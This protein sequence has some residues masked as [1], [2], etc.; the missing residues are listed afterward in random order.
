MS[1]NITGATD[2]AWQA[3]LT[4]FDGNVIGVGAMLGNIA[5]ESGGFEWAC[6][7]SIA[8]TVCRIYIS[9]VDNGDISRYEFITYG[10]NASTGACSY[11]TNHKGFGLCQW[12]Y[13]TRKAM[14]WDFWQ[15]FGGSIGS[16]DM[17]VAF[18]IYELEHSFPSLVEQLKVV[19]DL[20]SATALVLKVFEKP[21]DQS[22]AVITQRT[23]W[24]QQYIDYYGGTDLKFI[25]VVV[26]G[27]GTAVAN[28]TSG[29]AGYQI[30]L[31]A[32]AGTGDSFLY[33]QVDS[34]GVVLYYN[35]DVPDNA[36]NLGDFNVHITAVFTGEKPPTPTPTRKRKHW[37]R[38][39]NG[40]PI[41]E[42]PLLKH[43]G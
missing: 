3:L 6:E 25:V 9:K 38:S 43:G 5:G 34:G 29:Q 15:D 8:Q 19:T 35:N 26:E 11:S 14:L 17:Q 10:V 39:Y 24:A 22:E 28:P 16:A 27:N 4:L 32:Y 30:A 7:P 1:F 41:W 33:W 20:R 2:K 31:H 23:N 36:F 12:T 40:M 18:L 21:A 37:V 13:T 42:Y